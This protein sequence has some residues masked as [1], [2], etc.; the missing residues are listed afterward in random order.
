MCERCMFHVVVVVVVVLS[1]WH[2]ECGK[3]LEIGSASPEEERSINHG[4]WED[5]TECTEYTLYM[6]CTYQL[7]AQSV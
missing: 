4:G 3:D 5:A 7:F 2:V 6:S 1:V